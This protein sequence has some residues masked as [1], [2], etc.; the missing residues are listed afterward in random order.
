MYI[1]FHGGRCCG[2]KHIHNLGFSP[3]F[4]QPELKAQHREGTKPY[5]P[6]K[7]GDDWK[8][9]YHL[10][11]FD[12]AAPQESSTN[13]LKRYL[14]FIKKYSPGCVVEIVLMSGATA[15]NQIKN[16]GPV[17]ES[18]G[19]REVGGEF[20]NSNSGRLL[21]I[22]HLVFQNGVTVKGEQQ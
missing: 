2:I 19:F 16:W 7:D 14:D 11:W 4:V 6:T 22:Y 1:T 8:A 5:D 18:L 10:N 9:S 20:K 21:Q 13:R 3:A 12:E 17:L 15:F